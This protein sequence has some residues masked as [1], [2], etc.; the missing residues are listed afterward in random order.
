MVTPEIADKRNLHIYGL[1]GFIRESAYFRGYRDKV[2]NI[3]A[4]WGITRKSKAKTDHHHCTHRRNGCR[5]TSIFQE[6]VLGVL[7]GHGQWGRTADSALRR[8]GQEPATTAARTAPERQPWRR[9]DRQAFPK[10]GRRAAPGPVPQVFVGCRNLPGTELHWIASDY[11]QG[12]LS[13]TASVET[14]T[15]KVARCRNYRISDATRNDCWG[16]ACD[17]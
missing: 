4:S 12:S 2:L 8:D 16:T 17:G 7:D 13:H 14:R 6:A 5:L 10:G 15:C 1:V 3:S 9:N 11:A